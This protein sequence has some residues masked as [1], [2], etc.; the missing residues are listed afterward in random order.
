MRGASRAT[1]FRHII[2]IDH[3]NAAYVG[4]LESSDEVARRSFA[5]PVAGE[6]EIL[7]IA[8]VAAIP[9]SFDGKEAELICRPRLAPK[10]D[11]RLARRLEATATCIS[12]CTHHELGKRR[13]VLLL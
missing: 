11:V 3:F 9:E 1:T 5:A 7:L 6:P 4:G 10:G 8:L 13:H 2:K 12:L